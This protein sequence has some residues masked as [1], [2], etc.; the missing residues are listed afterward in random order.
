[1]RE[2]DVVDELRIGPIRN[3][4]TFGC[5]FDPLAYNGELHAIA[6]AVRNCPD[7]RRDALQ[8]LLELNP[9]IL[10]QRAGLPLNT[11]VTHPWW[12]FEPTDNVLEW[13]DGCTDSWVLSEHFELPPL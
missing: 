5:D 13:F 10:V 9:I 8:R 2:P 4:K 3:L 7:D 11:G 6:A 12:S 1:M